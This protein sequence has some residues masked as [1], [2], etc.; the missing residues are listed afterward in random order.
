MY[1][2]KLEKELATSHWITN[3][4]VYLYLLVDN[5]DYYPNHLRLCNF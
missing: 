1:V 4:N 3:H 2:F 5:R